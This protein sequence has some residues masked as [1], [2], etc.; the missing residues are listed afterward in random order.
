MT[1]LQNGLLILGTDCILVGTAL[2]WAFIRF[3]S[4]YLAVLRGRAERDEIEAL[5][6]IVKAADQVS[7]WP[8]LD[9]AISQTMH[10]ALRKARAKIE[11]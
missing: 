6:E 8:D 10:A 11:G 7:G 5:M 2:A 1:P 4:G 9:G 3:L